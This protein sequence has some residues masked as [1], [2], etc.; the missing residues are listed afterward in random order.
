MA[1]LRPP[2]WRRCSA[3]ARPRW[4]AISAATTTQL[5]AIRKLR[6][7]RIVDRGDAAFRRPGRQEGAEQEV[8]GAPVEQCLEDLLAEQMADALGIADATQHDAAGDEQ[9]HE[10]DDVGSKAARKP[11]RRMARPDGRSC[12]T[13][14]RLSSSALASA[15]RPAT[16]MPSS[17]RAV[18]PSTI[19]GRLPQ[20]P[21][22]GGDLMDGEIHPLGQDLEEGA[23]GGIGR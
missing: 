21:A 6:A 1:A 4:P 18:R 20:M 5:R 11:E 23:V 14:A 10:G 19:T 7:V 22:Q 2:S 15:A 16:T 12:R 8:E 17:S 13:R 9:R 3:G